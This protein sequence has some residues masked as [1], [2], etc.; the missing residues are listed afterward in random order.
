MLD[1][2]DKKLESSVDSPMVVLLKEEEVE[3]FK[4]NCPLYPRGEK[5]GD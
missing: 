1:S 3:A 5:G 2:G 4:Q